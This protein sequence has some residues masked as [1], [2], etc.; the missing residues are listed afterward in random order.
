MSSWA[1][2]TLDALEI[3]I[4]LA[5]GTTTQAIPVVVLTASLHLTAAHRPHVWGR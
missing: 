1:L 2:K 3:L 4:R 5:E